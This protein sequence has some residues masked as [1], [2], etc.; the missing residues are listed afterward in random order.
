[1]A[2]GGEEVTLDAQS[3]LSDL[4][5]NVKV[6]TSISTKLRLRLSMMLMRLAAFVAGYSIKITSEDEQ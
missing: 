1:M 4:V 3:L 2:N 5:I 6:H